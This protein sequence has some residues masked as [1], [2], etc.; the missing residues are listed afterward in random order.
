MQFER[1]TQDLIMQVE[2]LEERLSSDDGAAGGSN[3][4]Q[5]RSVVAFV[6]NVVIL[7]SSECFLWVGKYAIGCFRS[8]AS[9]RQSD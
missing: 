9:A 5:V 1:R 6:I 2:D 8:E 4:M 7:N 3:M